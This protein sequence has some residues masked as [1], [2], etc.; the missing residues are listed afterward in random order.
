MNYKNYANFDQLK[1]SNGTFYV[2]ILKKKLSNAY[3]DK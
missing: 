3:I 1:C 2:L